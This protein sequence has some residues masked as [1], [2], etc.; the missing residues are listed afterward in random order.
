MPEQPV[1]NPTEAQRLFDELAA[2]GKPVNFTFPTQQHPTSLKTA[3]YMQS[4]LNQFKNV[5]MEIE[6][7]EAGGYITKGLVNRDFQAQNS[8]IW[9]ADPD[10]GIDSLYRTGSPTNYTGH[11]TPP[12][13]LHSTRHARP[14]RWRRG[15]PRTPNW[16]RSPRRMCRCS[17]G[18]RRS[19]RSST[20]RTSPGSPW[21]TTVP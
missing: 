11:P 9:L 8:G 5:K 17:S 19:P 7:I 4:R 12:P 15:V 16:S 14:R 13:T 21:A 3:E 10:P 1:Y 6:A 2:E 20:G 18:S